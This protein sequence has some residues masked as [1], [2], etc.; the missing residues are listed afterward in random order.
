MRRT[1]FLSI[2]LALQAMPVLA[3]DARVASEAIPAQSLDR[4]LNALSRQTGLQFVYSAQAAG[5][6]QTRAIP[7]GLAAD[8]VLTQL[9]AGTGLRSRPSGERA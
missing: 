2:V 8:D 5:N 3:Q 4:S 1:L 7:A 9:L 6:P